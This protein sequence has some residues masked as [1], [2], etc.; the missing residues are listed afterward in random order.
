MVPLSIRNW[1]RW[2]KMRISAVS[3]CKY[4]SDKPQ[5]TEA[6]PTEPPPTQPQTKVSLHQAANLI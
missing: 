6:Q 1:A 4:T 3:F 5:Q 2:R